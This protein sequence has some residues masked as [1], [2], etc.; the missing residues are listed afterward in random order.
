M[1]SHRSLRG[2]DRYILLTTASLMLAGLLMVASASMD[3]SEKQFGQCFHYVIRH[4]IYLGISIS[5]AL[6]V[7]QMPTE[8]W[9]KIALNLLMLTILLL[10]VVLIPGIGKAVN[11]SRRWLLLGFVRFQ[12]SELA[13]LTIIIY[14][15]RYLDRY[16]EEITH[17]WQTFLKPMVLIGINIVLLLK[18]PDLGAAVVILITSI[19]LLFLAGV[20]IV[21]FFSFLMSAAGI[22][23]ALIMS[24]T[25]RMS[26]MISFFNPWDYPFSHGYQLTQALIACGR[27]ELWGKGLGESIQKLF[28]L[29]EAHTDFIFAVLIEELG[30]IG[31]IILIALFLVLV[32]Y[33][34]LLGWEC[35]LSYQKFNAYLAYGIGI[36]LA[37]SVMINIGVN[38]GL[39][40]TKGLTLPLISYGGN[41]LMI[42]T[43]M[44]AILIRINYELQQNIF[45]KRYAR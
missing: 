35:M 25:Y 3:L 15:A 10:I 17:Q 22:I 29:P 13:K 20:P 34:F 40:P 12:V 5:I 7:F 14:L 23:V 36:Y 37:V 45:F 26:R 4:S 1:L 31:G 24:S 30:L 32:G 11:G 16:S 43:V 42:T 8:L 21:T 2:Y 41:S 44:I 33:A 39:L 9:R 38:I 27:G 6:L 28:Y 19:S 18:E